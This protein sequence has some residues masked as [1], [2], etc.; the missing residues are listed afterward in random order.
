[1]PRF[2]LKFVVCANRADE[3]E[4]GCFL[5]QVEVAEQTV[6]DLVFTKRKQFSSLLYPLP[7]FSAVSLTPLGTQQSTPPAR[8]Y[9]SRRGKVAY[10]GFVF[11][12]N[13]WD[14]LLLQKPS[15]PTILKNKRGAVVHAFLHP[16]KLLFCLYI[17]IIHS[18]FIYNIHSFTSFLSIAL[19]YCSWNY[20]SVHSYAFQF[21]ALQTNFSKAPFFPAENVLLLTRRFVLTTE[22]IKYIWRSRN[23]D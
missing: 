3:K 15:L 12:K 5:K 22:D 9:W 21:A 7:L 18:K 13:T 20:N 8:H 19:K 4:V 17:W 16:F 6:S 2:L 10:K 14:L 11:L 1:M 23:A